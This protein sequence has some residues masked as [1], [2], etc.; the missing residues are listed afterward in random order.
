MFTGFQVNLY[1]A[2]VA[3]SFAF[4]TAI[5][6][7]ETFRDSD[8]PVPDHVEVRLAGL[9]LGLAS[10]A[11]AREHHGLDVDAEGTGAELVL[12]SDDLAADWADLLAAGATVM[13]EP[14][15]LPTGLS[16]AWAADP[17]GNPVHLV[18]RRAG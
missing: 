17:D 16:V 6:G 18:M 2:D 1:V 7:V 10:V 4:Y 13:A 14:E 8:A 12:W 5:G 3:R 11:A 15:H 9:T